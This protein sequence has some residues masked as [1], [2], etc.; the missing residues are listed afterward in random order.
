MSEFPDF[1]IYPEDS[2]NF[3]SFEDKLNESQ[4]QRQYEFEQRLIPAPETQ[5]F[6][7]EMND[8]TRVIDE[9]TGITYGVYQVNR[10][11]SGKPLV[12]NMSW[13]VAAG[14]KPGRGEVKAYATHLRRPIT[15][16]D[17]EAHG[18]TDIPKRP[19]RKGI[20]FDD[21]AAAHLRVINH[22]GIVEF[23]IEG[24]S[25]G[26]VIAAKIAQQAGSRVGTLV[27]V[28]TLSFEEMKERELAVGFVI[29]ENKHQ[30]RYVREATPETRAEAGVGFVGTLAS[31]PTL[32]R[33][34]AMMTQEVVPEAIRQLSP[35][36]K[37]Y[38]F[39]GSKEEVTD[40]RAHLQVVRERNKLLP[41]SS[42]IYIL[43]QE[44]H[45]W[46]V[47]INSIAEAVASVL[48]KKAL[49]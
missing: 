44:T 42:S 14:E 6:R 21:I 23:D 4:F 49:H 47:H 26:G 34:A 17:T 39:V 10:D 41:G 12:L 24:L 30:K 38:D 2:A 27:T 28:S 40:W 32:L 18:K 13:S 16:I 35:D 8:V 22:L 20:T 1:P 45:A 29:K 7:D 5:Q 31:V 43:G 11:M 25:L 9:K 33:L 36:T 37:W 15:V 3:S 46:S 48:E 19:W